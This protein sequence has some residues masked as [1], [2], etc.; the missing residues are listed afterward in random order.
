M[1]K[2]MYAWIEE[3]IN[4]PKKKSMPVLSFPGIQLID[5]TVR[6]LVASGELQTKCMK[7]IADKFDTAA[8]VSNMDLSVE[9]EAFGAKVT[10]SDDEVPTVIGRLIDTMEDAEKLAVPEVGTARTGEYI[11]AVA[12]AVE[13]ITDRPVFAGIIG[14]FSLAGR[15]MEMTEI[16]YKCIEEPE[17]V[18]L[19]LEKCTQFLTKYILAFKEVGANGIVMA[20]PAAGLLS[21]SLN[22]DFS[23]KFV[24][25]IIG[26]VQDE[27][28]IVIYHN[29]GNTVP[30][31]NDI[32]ST[33]VKALHF[34]NFIKMSDV[35]NKIPS[36]LLVMGNVDPA[37]QFRNGTKESLQETTLSLLNELKG[38]PNFVISSGCDIPPM[39][40]IDNIE[41]F[42][43]TVHN[44]YK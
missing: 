26:A 43:E 34:G 21:P 7:A 3:T 38:Y 6:D 19:V 39:T 20:E 32:L 35:I 16:M 8:S 1:K 13:E 12:G 17:V 36:D 18:D 44:F 42:F 25:N 23:S 22:A 9:A 10:F 14:P 24:K 28:F 11:K 4:N 37:G 31:L 15:L 2:N 5:T 33:G 27:S 40:P 30:L 41:A 29:C